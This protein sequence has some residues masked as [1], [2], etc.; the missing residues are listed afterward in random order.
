MVEA[1]KID[2]AYDGLKISVVVVRPE[3]TPKAVLQIAHGMCG[4]KERYMPFMEFMSMNGIACIANDHRGHGESVKSEKDLGYMY[5]G[6]AEAL[7][8]DMMQVSE[9]ARRTFP[10]SPL[11]LLGHSMGSLASR[12]CI[13]KD[14]SLFSGLVLCGSPVYNPLSSVAGRVLPFLFNCGF[15]HF[16]PKVF[17]RIVTDWYNRN[18]HEEGYQAWTCSD[19][20]VRKSFQESPKNNYRFTLNGSNCMVQLMKMSYCKEGWA[21][22]SPRMPVLFLAGE[23]D[24]AT[25]GHAGM[26]STAEAMRKAG[27]K[28]IGVKTYPSMRHEILNEI[29]R[30][31]VWQD[32]RDFMFADIQKL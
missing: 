3:G 1:M 10:Y 12:A 29:G 7:V 26:M 11:F 21:L 23:D 6:G 18:F 31:E 22:K 15:G 32:I 20:A 8:D 25:G 14:D 19:P 2:S 30:E 27:Y 9:Y 5:E 16:R 4:S 13:R 17:P 28:N 24:P